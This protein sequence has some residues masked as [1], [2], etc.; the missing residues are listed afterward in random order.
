MAPCWPILAGWLEAPPWWLT[1]TVWPESAPGGQ[2]GKIGSG[3][4][5]GSQIRMGILGS[6]PGGR[7][8]QVGLGALPGSQF[9]QVGLGALLSTQFGQVGHGTPPKGQ[10]RVIGLGG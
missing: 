8:G 10:F 6:T 4:P 1:W 9:R 7:F 5:P 2:F 3:V